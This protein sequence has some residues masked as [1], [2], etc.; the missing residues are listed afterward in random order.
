MNKK[1]NETLDTAKGILIILMVLGHSGCPGY[2]ADVIYLFHMPCFFLISGMC[3][4][5]K[6][7]DNKLLFIRRKIKTLYFPFVKWSFLFLIFHNF[8]FSLNLYANPYD[9]SLFLRRSLGVLTMTASEQ[10][11]GKRP[12]VF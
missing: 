3:L 9:M 5:D 2:I 6:Y 10:L 4:S 7:A 8:L 1:R 12:K 11:L